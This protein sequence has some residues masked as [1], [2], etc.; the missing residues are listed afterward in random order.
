MDK[1]IASYL[2][3]AYFDDLWSHKL[4]VYFHKPCTNNLMIPA[5]VAVYVLELP[6]ENMLWPTQ[7]FCHSIR[8]RVVSWLVW[9]SCA[10]ALHVQHIL[11]LS[12]MTPHK[13][14]TWKWKSLD[15]WKWNKTFI[16]QQLQ[17]KLFFPNKHPS[18]YL[19]SLSMMV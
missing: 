15:I 4:V 7:L 16:T 11:S 19:K 14:G 13:M 10:L 18:M 2:W 5:H 12:W 9:R 1:N 8:D 6:F 3:G 17:L